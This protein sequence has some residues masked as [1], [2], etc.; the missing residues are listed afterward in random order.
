LRLDSRARLVFAEIYPSLIAVPAL[1]GMPK[2]AAQVVAAARYFSALDAAGTLE[3]LFGG[4]T[5][6]DSERHCIEEEE[7][8]ILGALAP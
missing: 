1:P 7:G 5:L 3:R 2:D 4:G 6:S 8:W